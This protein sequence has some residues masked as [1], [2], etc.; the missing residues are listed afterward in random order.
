MVVACI[1]MVKALANMT[2][3]RMKTIMD[4]LFRTFIS[5]LTMNCPQN[6]ASTDTAIR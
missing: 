3:E 5:L 1:P 2:E 6:P 4:A